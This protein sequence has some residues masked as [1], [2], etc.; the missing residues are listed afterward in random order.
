MKEDDTNRVIRSGRFHVYIIRC[1]DGSLYTG[2]TT[3]LNK[4]ISQ[5]ATGKGARYTRG[6]GPI[7]L[8]WSREYRYFRNAVKAEARIKRMP[9]SEKWQLIKKRKV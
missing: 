7:D 5:H 8:V 9:R 2:F 3:D 1:G 4:R 6:R